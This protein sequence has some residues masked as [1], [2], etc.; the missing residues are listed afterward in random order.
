MNDMKI[1]TK[2]VISYIDMLG[3]TRRIEENSSTISFFTMKNIYEQMILAYTKGSMEQ[4]HIKVKIFSDNIIIARETSEDSDA[5]AINLNQMI[6]LSAGFQ[7]FAMASG[8]PVRGGITVG[9]LYIDDMFVWGK[10]LLRSYELESK[11]AVTPRIV[12]DPNLESEIL[13]QYTVNC[14]RKDAGLPIVNYLSMC[15]NEET[16]ETVKNPIISLLKNSDEKTIGKIEW[17]KDDFNKMC[18]EKQY[19]NL[20]IPN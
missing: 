13:D 8:W 6:A 7:F 19:Y 9:N 14:W 18:H 3:T 15:S 2:H 4:E 11:V 16:M 10:G 5:I 20:I 1:D 17:L 12:I